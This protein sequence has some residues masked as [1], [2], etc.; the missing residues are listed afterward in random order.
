MR[1]SEEQEEEEEEFVIATKRVKSN[2][3]A[4]AL[5]AV[6]RLKD[7]MVRKTIEMTKIKYD[8]YKLDRLLTITCSFGSKLDE[9]NREIQQMVVVLNENEKV[10]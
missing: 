9:E 1:R 2:K 8:M 6:S 10:Q 4:S 3:S 7:D 5:R